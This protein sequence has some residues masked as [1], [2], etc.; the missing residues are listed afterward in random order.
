M[1]GSFYCLQLQ[2]AQTEL[3]TLT[4]TTRYLK[5][6]LRDIEEAQNKAIR[7]ERRKAKDELARMKE[8][9][10]GILEKERRA[11]RDEL[12]RQITE[13][14]AYLMEAT[15]QDGDYTAEGR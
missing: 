9:M 1:N 3:A 6:Q 5:A 12:K 7:E 15:G 2:E 14:R 11:M 8:A 10:V 4:T 13:L